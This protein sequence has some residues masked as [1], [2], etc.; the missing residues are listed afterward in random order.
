[1]APPFKVAEFDIMYNEG[2]STAGDLLDLGVAHDIISKRGAYYRYNEELIGQGRESSKDYLRQNGHIADEIDNLIRSKAGLPQRRVA[3]H[4]DAASAP[5][6]SQ[7]AVS[8]PAVTKG[9]TPAPEAA[10]KPT[11]TLTE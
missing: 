3:I 4:A 7:P 11:A 2:I 9:V 6:A 1:V 10:A 8:K 5:A